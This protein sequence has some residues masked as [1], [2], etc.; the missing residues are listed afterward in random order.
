MLC[1]TLTQGI[2]VHL[3][4]AGNT[5]NVN[6]YQQTSGNKRNQAIHKYTKKIQQKKLLVQQTLLL[7]EIVEADDIWGDIP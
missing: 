3:G 4:R 1:L 6:L 2:T 7:P 5:G